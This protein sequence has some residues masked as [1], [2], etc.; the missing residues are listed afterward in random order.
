MAAVLARFKRKL[1]GRPDSEHVQVLVRIAITTLFCMY[2]GLHMAAGTTAVTDPLLLTWLILLGELLLSLGLLGAI[3]LRPGISHSRRWLGMLADYAAMGGVMWL[4]GETAAPLYGVYLWVTIGNGLRYGPRYL[5]FATAL[6]AVSFFAMMRFTVYWQANSYLAWGLLVGLIAVPLY[7]ASLLKALTGAIEAARHAN[8][9][10][11]RFLANMSHEL[12]TP[13]NSI[14]GMSELLSAS[15]LNAEQRE[16]AEMVRT[17]AQTLLLLIEDV[18]DISAIEAGKINRH[19]VDFELSSLLSQIY[20][21]LHPQA[22]DKGL[23]LHMEADIR[24]A[25]AL[26][27]DSDHLRQILLNLIHN[28]IKFTPTGS[29]GLQVREIKRDSQHIWLKFSVRDTGIGVPREARQR[30]FNAFEQIDAGR[31]RKFGGSGLG[32]SIA[33]SLAELMGGTI[34]LEDNPGGGS[35]FWVELP[36]ALRPASTGA[37]APVE[38]ATPMQHRATSQ[39][40]L[41]SESEDAVPAMADLTI[42]ANKV[43]EFDDP[44][45]RHRIRVRS[46]QVVIVDDQPAN[47]VVLQRLLEK[48]GHRTIFAE[49]GEQALNY[50]VDFEPDLMIV[51]LH[52][53]GLSGLDVIRQARVLQAGQRARTPI[54]VLSADATVEAINETRQAGGYA[55]LTKPIVVGRLLDLLTQVADGERSDHKTLLPAA[56]VATGAAPIH[57]SDALQELAALGLG[58]KFL[59]D[60]VEQCIRDIGRSMSGLQQASGKGDVEAIRE[61][62]HAMRGV[63][64][65]VGAMALV[66]RCRQL[67]QMQAPT[68]RSRAKS[69]IAD[70]DTLVER[71]ASAAR[72]ALDQLPP[73]S[74]EG[75]QGEGDWDA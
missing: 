22:H 3:F 62:A 71:S 73:P 53:P 33:K 2:L 45:V 69:L 19:A 13:L 58:E 43:I 35:H 28:A 66:E 32:T 23:A 39:K 60:F 49:D 21:M 30:I 68:L 74:S 27:G 26:H 14:L 56:T 9:A 72:A 37:D 5:Y 57:K 67:M 38:P 46:L 16:S 6:A 12:R 4:Q 48:A 65:S 10:K 18:L 61:H 44:F 51:D 25:N 34:G 36:F 70:M 54:V 52:M 17:A 50:L 8:Q 64:E 59:R 55:Y 63:A 42:S 47:R 29:V 15:K 1:A 31:D 11:S 75:R 40:S 20:R 41:A 24:I 7:F